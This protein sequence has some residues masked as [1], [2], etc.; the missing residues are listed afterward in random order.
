MPS[1]ASSRFLADGRFTEGNN[2][3]VTFP[4]S[5]HVL[6][7]TA[8][9]APLGTSDVERLLFVQADRNRPDLRKRVARFLGD[10]V[11]SLVLE[12]NVE[13]VRPVADRETG[14]D[15]RLAHGRAPRMTGELGAF[16]VR[17]KAQ[18]ATHPDW[19]GRPFRVTLPAIVC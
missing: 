15:D 19:T 10:D 17:G 18:R 12:R 8:D 13:T 5:R 9:A 3:E 6:D 2:P 4:I 16:L 14:M 7:P 11:P 1:G